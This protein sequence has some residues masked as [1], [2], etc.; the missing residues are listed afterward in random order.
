[1][2]IDIIEIK[3]PKKFKFEIYLYIDHLFE[4]DNLR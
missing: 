3:K 4:S 2:K 1:M